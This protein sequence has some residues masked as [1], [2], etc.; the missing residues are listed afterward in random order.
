MN[1]MLQHLLL[2]VLKSV[3]NNKKEFERK[4]CFTSLNTRKYSE[5]TQVTFKG[6]C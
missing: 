3:I 2:Y 1:S 5:T 4:V 6:N